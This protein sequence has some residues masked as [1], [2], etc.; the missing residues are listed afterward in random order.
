MPKTSFP[1]NMHKTRL[2]ELVE[3]MQGGEKQT[4]LAQANK[5]KEQHPDNKR[6]AESIVWAVKRYRQ[7]NTCAHGNSKLSEDQE[8]LYL[9]TVLGFSHVNRPLSLI[10]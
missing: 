10:S 7:K 8:N 4:K 1:T 6:S 3:F 2:E 9:C 5:W